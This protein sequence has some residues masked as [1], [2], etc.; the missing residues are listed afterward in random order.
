MERELSV[1]CVCFF[2]SG[3]DVTINIIIMIIIIIQFVCVFLVPCQSG[4]LRPA[5]I[6]HGASSS[7]LQFNDAG[8]MLTELPGHL[9]MDAYGCSLYSGS[10]QV[11]IITKWC[12]HQ[13]LAGDCEG[14]KEMGVIQICLLVGS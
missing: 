14:A 11:E 12:W 6:G 5:F 8:C 3:D 7:P 4:V 13:F 10:L 2:L 1:L 9:F